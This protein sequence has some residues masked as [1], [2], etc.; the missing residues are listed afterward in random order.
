MY[1]L[2]ICPTE[3]LTSPLEGEVC[4]QSERKTASVRKQGEGNRNKFPLFTPHPIFRYSPYVLIS[5]IDLSPKE[6]GLRLHEVTS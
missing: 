6:R 1:N 2:I 4:F 3:N 5:K